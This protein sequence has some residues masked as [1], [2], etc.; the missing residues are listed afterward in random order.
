MEADSIEEFR[1]KSLRTM[2]YTHYGNKCF[3]RAI[4]LERRS[5]PMYMLPEE[6]EEEKESE[7]ERIRT[8]P[9]W[10]TDKIMETKAARSGMKNEDEG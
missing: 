7:W 3:R 9:K 10:V 8:I 4:L 6:T 1:D 2:L 5:R